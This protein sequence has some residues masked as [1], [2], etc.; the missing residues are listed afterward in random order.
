MAHKQNRAHAL[1]RRLI[2]LYPRGFREQFGES[3]EQTFIDLYRESQQEPARR[4]VG[5]V[6]WVFAETAVGVVREH[7]LQIKQGEPM[8]PFTSNLRTAAIISFFLVLPYFILELVFTGSNAIYNPAVAVYGILWLLPTA[9]ITLLM[10][11][12]RTV[13]AGN[14][15]LAQPLPLLFRLVFLALLAVMWVAIIADQFPCFLGVP[16]CD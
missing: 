7:A 11:M 14:S 6:L 3:M 15:L 10:P 9:F 2:G 12:V 1:Y 4:R 8:N 16:N 5:F 13:R